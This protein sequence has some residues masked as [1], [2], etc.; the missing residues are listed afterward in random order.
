MNSQRRKNF[1][2]EAFKHKVELDP[3]YAD[4]TWKVLE[5]A[6]HEIYNNNA[7]RLSFEELYRFVP[8]NSFSILALVIHQ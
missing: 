5:H 7:S 3:K 6:I 2:I 1:K 8:V 4:R